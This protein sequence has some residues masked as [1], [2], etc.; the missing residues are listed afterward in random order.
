MR[1]SYGTVQR[2]FIVILR[3]VTLL[4]CGDGTG[5]SWLGTAGYALLTVQNGFNNSPPAQLWVGFNS[6]AEF[7]K[8]RV[9]AGTQQS[10]LVES[11]VV[12]DS[13]Q[14]LGFFLDP[15]ST[16]VPEGLIPELV[17]PMHTVSDNLNVWNGQNVAFLVKVEQAN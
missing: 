12:A 9:L 6:T 14:P 17:Q 1:G 8:M 3:A 7:Q 11:V 5:P 15:K 2:C 4:S 13:R 16:S 10:I